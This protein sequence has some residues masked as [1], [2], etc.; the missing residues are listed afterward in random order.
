MKTLLRCLALLALLPACAVSR[1][2]SAVNDPLPREDGGAHLDSDAARDAADDVPEPSPETTE[3]DCWPSTSDFQ[4]GDSSFGRAYGDA[5]STC[6]G[7]VRW[8]CGS[9]L[10][11][12]DAEGCVIGLG[13]EV[14]NV[15]TDVAELWF[16]CMT[17]QL[18]AVCSRCE[19]S[20]TRRF[21]ESC[22]LL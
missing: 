2:A 12:L 7:Q 14:T 18:G 10:L 22:T 17:E 21:Y 4:S 11:D 9:V 1:S 3:P 13:G 15:S 5:K 19:A 20:E 16:D 6:D 8:I